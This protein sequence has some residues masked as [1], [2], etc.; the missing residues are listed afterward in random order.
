MDEEKGAG[1]IFS[2]R[3]YIWIDKCVYKYILTGVN[4]KKPG[5]IP[6]TG[7]SPTHKA[8][9]KKSLLVLQSPK[10]SIMA[11]SGGRG[12]ELVG[13]ITASRRSWCRAPL[14]TVSGP[15]LLIRNLCM[16]PTNACLPLGQE[17]E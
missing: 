7:V 4:N 1:I 15:S 16:G 2:K 13:G 8:A 3:T 5:E 6:Q 11:E 9:Q 17:F 14:S 12:R 10:G